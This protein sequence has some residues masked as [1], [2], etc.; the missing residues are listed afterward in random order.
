MK[1]AGL[2]RKGYTAWGAKN[3]LKGVGKPSMEVW[4]YGRL[5]VKL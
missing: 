4:K 3:T 2:N 1:I 5:E